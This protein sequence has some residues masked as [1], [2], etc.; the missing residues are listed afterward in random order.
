MS[1]TELGVRI[2]V[3]RKKLK[4]TRD[5]FKKITGIHEQ[6]LYGWEKRGF[7]PQLDAAKPIFKCFPQYILWLIIGDEFN[8]YNNKQISPNQ[9][10]LTIKE[11]V[12]QYLEY[13]KVE[14]PQTYD[15]QERTLT[16]IVNFFN[17]NKAIELIS[18]LDIQEFKT[19]RLQNKIKP[20]TIN[21][22]LAVLSA[23]FSYY[24]TYVNKYYTPPKITKIKESGVYPPKF[25]SKK[26]LYA[27]YKI[28][29]KFANIWKFMAN[30]GLRISEFC[31]LRWQDTKD[32]YIIVKGK[33]GKV[34]N[35]A[36]NET[37]KKSL[38]KMNKKNDIISEYTINFLQK[39]FRNNCTDAGIKE[40]KRGIHC[41]RHT[42]G[43]HLVEQDV[44]ITKIQELM[45]HADIR[46][47]QKYVHQIKEVLLEAVN[48]ISL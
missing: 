16:T 12:R 1:I 22:N 20:T 34:R 17:C 24:T 8:K 48:R 29:E 13:F 42:F 11:T 10:S 33:G 3:L 2:L 28:D 7:V 45:G 35:I 44:E 4:L 46:I 26:E 41:L 40:N 18:E 39:R 37:S 14:F 38:S 47:T 25:Y 32:D 27:I 21:R 36:L 9:K 19:I 31:N 23:L 43:T 5:E 30:T 15:T 6:T